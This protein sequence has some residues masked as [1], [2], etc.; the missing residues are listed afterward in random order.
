VDDRKR[1]RYYKISYLN[2]LNN[3]RYMNED[4]V[5]LSSDCVGGDG[6]ELSHTGAWHVYVYFIHGK[7]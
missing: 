6:V 5:D 1:G 3:I 4:K 7:T 2:N